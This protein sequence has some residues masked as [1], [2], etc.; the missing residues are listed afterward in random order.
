MGQEGAEK[1]VEEADGIIHIKLCILREGHW[2]VWAVL[3]RFLRL[4]LYTQ[5]FNGRD[6]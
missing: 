6:T 3:Q 1:Q 5:F 2:Y 4:W